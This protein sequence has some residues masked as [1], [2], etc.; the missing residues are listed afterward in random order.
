MPF[1]VPDAV[2]PP[3]SLILVTGAN[4]LIGSHV[5]DQALAAGYRVRG[6]VRDL[7]RT[8]WLQDLF[9]TKY[10][11]DKFELALVEDMGK[12]GAFDEV[13]KGN[14]SLPHHISARGPGSYHA[15]VSGVIHVAASVN[16]GS[17]PNAAITPVIQ[18]TTGLASSAAKVSSVKRFVLTSSS[19][20]ATLAKPGIEFEIDENTWCEDAIKDA[21]APPPYEAERGWSVYGAMKVRGSCTSKMP[22]TFTVISCRTG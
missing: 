4:G 3:S 10:G 17:D 9:D 2:L 11:K 15:D 7:K 22:N 12:D 6:T 16:P 14:Y 8:S 18:Q 20:A 1:Q 13:L 19:C 21:W 5:A